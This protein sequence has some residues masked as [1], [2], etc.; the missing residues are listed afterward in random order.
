MATKTEA[1][2]IATRNA[3]KTFEFRQIFGARYEVQGL[4]SHPELPEVAETGTTFEENSQL[5][6][7]AISRQIPDTLVLADD[8]GLEVDALGGAP[9]VYS[10]RFSGPEATDAANRALLLERLQAEEA[11]GKA[12]SARFRCVLTLARNGEV[13]AQSTGTVEGIIANREKGGHGFGYDPLFIPEGRCQTFAELSP[14]AKHRLSHRGRAVEAL[15]A[16]MQERAL[17]SAEK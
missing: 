9:G 13:I 6:A 1:L 4:S 15:R 7:L 2:L 8:S 12:R 14:R 17:G 5:K 3:H 11:R 16:R 10:A